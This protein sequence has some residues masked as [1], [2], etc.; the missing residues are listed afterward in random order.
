MSESVKNV[1][2]QGQTVLQ[3]LRVLVTRPAHQ[4]EGL[5]EP[6]KH[7]GASVIEL[8][9]IYL[10]PPTSWE[11]FD[12]CFSRLREFDWLLFVS[13]NAVEC[14]LARLHSTN[15][16]LV[17]VMRKCQIASIGATTSEVLKNSG[18]PVNFQP[19]KFVAEE[20][21]AQFPGY[22]DGLSGLRMLWPKG[23]I[24]RTYIKDKFVLA[25]ATVTT[26]CAYA[27][28]GPEH[29]REAAYELRQLLLKK[30]VDVVT[31]T[32]SEA[33]RSFHRLLT[34]NGA[35]INEFVDS[36]IIA[37]IGPETGRTAKQLLGKAD[38]HALE[39]SVQGLVQAIVE[40]CRSSAFDAQN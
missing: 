25:G 10:L 4:A 2:I 29:P 18:M 11:I 33:V 26:A 32:S 34:A 17:D 7:L 12:E 8:P 37:V 39:Y 31:F 14:T 22:P 28:G 21:V 15:P 23:D 30:E 5:S 35:P 1:S 13:A 20:F 3:G 38:V 16:K 6:L 19:D 40:R 9:L 36:V 27:I 24:G